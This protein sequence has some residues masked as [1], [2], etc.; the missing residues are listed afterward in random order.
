MCADTGDITPAT[1][2][3]HI[4]P[5]RGD[6]ELFW[7]RSNWQPLCAPHH[8]ITKTL[9]ESSSKHAV[10]RDGWPVPNPSRDAIAP[11]KYAHA[12]YLAG[13]KSVQTKKSVGIRSHPGTKG[14]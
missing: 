13:A 3:D 7:D 4:I 6:Q 1:V 14:R 5:H 8:D 12:G 2:V 11:A 9:E 10:D